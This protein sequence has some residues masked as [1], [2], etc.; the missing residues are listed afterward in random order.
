VPAALLNLVV[1]SSEPE[2]AE[3]VMASGAK[4]TVRELA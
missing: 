1:A 4:E 3:V 2:V